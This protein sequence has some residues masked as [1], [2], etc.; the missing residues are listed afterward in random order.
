VR[1][2]DS[3]QLVQAVKKAGIEVV[4]LPEKRA[5]D[6][7]VLPQIRQL[8]RDFAPDIVQSHNVKSHF[9]VKLLGL[10]KLFPWIA[11][12]HGYTKTNVRIGIYNH[13]NRYSL[14]SAD[15]VFVV[16]DAFSGEIRRLSVSPTRMSVRHNMVLPFLRTA[17]EDLAKV[18]ERLKIPAGI[19]V[20]L[21]VGRLS[22]EKGHE[23]LVR[24]IAVVRQRAP[25]IDFR[26]VLLGEGPEHASIERLSVQLGVRERIVF[27]GHHPDTATYYSLADVFILPS[28]SEGS[29]NALL[30]AM[31]AGVPTVATAVGGVPEIAVHEENALLVAK[32]DSVKMG[33]E[34]IRLLTDASLRARLVENSRQVTERYTRESY[35]KNV[36]EI[37]KKVLEARQKT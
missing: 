29:P 2:G 21:C 34:I 22:K 37:Y 36:V 35:R 19:P 3:G 23:D 14:R 33:E 5:L 15:H 32:G 16:C 12:H 27:A 11:F 13:L 10:H 1:P 20:L 26:V 6:P 30:E 9:M 18:R 4:A 25:A 31:A 17:A 7:R 8:I 24:A 28:H